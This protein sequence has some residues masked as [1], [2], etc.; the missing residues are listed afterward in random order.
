MGLFNNI[1][2]PLDGSELSAQALPAASVMARASGASMTLLRS[3]DSVPEWQVDAGQRRFR[4]SLAVAEHDRILA[5]LRAEKQLLESRGVG[6]RIDV[7]ACEGSAHESIINLANDR[8][9]ALIAMSTHGR[10]GFSRMLMGSV[11]AKVVRAVC[12]PTL[13]VR[14]NETDCPVVPHH[15]DNIIVPLDGSEFAESA[16]PY[17]QELAA[18]FGAR[19][20][21]VR[22]TPDSEY[23]RVN[24]EWGAGHDF[25]TA[26]HLDPDNL[27]ARL[28]EKAKAYLWRKADDLSAQF[29]AF[30]V[31]AVHRLEAPSETVI[32]LTRQLDNGLVVMASHGRRGIGRALLGSVADRIVRHSQMPTLLVRG[33]ARQGSDM[34]TTADDRAMLEA[35]RELIAV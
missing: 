13:I 18:A 22:T 10:G 9:D 15:L 30:D 23:F 31:E 34:P 7:M 8:P 11:T 20:T 35:D 28:S 19:L 33:P 27:A 2:V 12:N 6:A 25:S 5:S 1:I 26:R 32:R 16:L 21:L 29:P 24:T 17:G 4:G 14:C 3:F